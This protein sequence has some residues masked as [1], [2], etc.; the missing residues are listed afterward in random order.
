MS[1]LWTELGRAPTEAI[2]NS[3]T[4][5]NEKLQRYNNIAA[6]ISGGADSDIMLDLLERF[7]TTDNVHYV[8]FDTG[9]EYQA[10]KDHL[11]ELEQKYGI[12]IEKIKAIKPIPLACRQYGQPFVSKRVSNMIRRLQHNHFQWE[13][14]PLS[15]LMKKYP[16]CK[17]ALRWWCNDWGDHSKFNIAYNKWLKEFLICNPPTFKIS[18]LCCTWAKKRV[19]HKYVKDNKVDLN[20][21]GVRK[22]EGG[23]RATAYKTC[24][25]SGELTDSAD[26][27]RPIFWY[28]NSDKEAYEKEYGICHSKCYTEYGLSRTGCA[29]CPFGRDFETELSIIKTYEPKLYVAVNNIFKESYEYTRQYREFAKQQEQKGQ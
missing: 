15:Q 12:K 10:T 3:F 6:A 22:A 2:A 1:E 20:I 26:E 21:F 11:T 29:G 8:W 18:D 14:L 25:T 17:V 28:V 24:F 9:L 5:V 23:T 4:I 13:D 16:K 7:R 19:A 27:F